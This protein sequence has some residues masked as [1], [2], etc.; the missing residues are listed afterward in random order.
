MTFVS[1]LMK[2]RGYK[3]ISGK[4]LSNLIN[5]NNDLVII[6]VRDLDEYNLGHLPQS[7]NMPLDNF[8]YN[9]NN[10]Y[11]Y[12]NTPILV[13]C[14]KGIRSSEAADILVNQGFTK[15]YTIKG[16]LNNY[17]GKLVY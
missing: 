1:V 17:K 12:R 8:N 3:S 6:D 7:M 16:G 10:L 11:Y 2:K 9:L 13:Y 4:E 14:Q 15:V 5:R